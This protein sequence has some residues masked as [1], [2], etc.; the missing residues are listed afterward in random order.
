MTRLN[1]FRLSAFSILLTAFII[2]P[3]ISAGAVDDVS[4]V[5][6]TP[7][8]KGHVKVAD[9]GDG[10]PCGTLI[11]IDSEQ[12]SEVPLDKNNKDESL[13]SRPLVGIKML[14]GFKRK[15]DSWKKGRIYNPEDGKT[16][17]ASIERLD[18]DMLKVKGCV[19]PFC[20]TQIWTRVPD[21]S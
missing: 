19:G 7:S 14:Y 10:T 17:G 3:A 9:C 15:K 5:W 20:Q 4:G 1:R 16:Y 13:T 12:A 11:W 8:K 2:S 21:G 18:D 6:L